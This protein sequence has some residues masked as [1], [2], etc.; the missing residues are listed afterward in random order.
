MAEAFVM[1]G[2]PKP[3]TR[4][5]SPIIKT[6][7]GVARNFKKGEGSIIF[8]FFVERIFFG[9]TNLKL[10]KKQGMLLGVR[11]LAPPENFSKFTY[12]NGYFSAF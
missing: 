1:W 10:I 6:G 3:M 9:K 11:G 4:F 8:T 12:C 7:S 5:F 2:G